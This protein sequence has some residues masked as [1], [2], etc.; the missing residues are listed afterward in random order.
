VR[1]WGR[2]ARK[3]LRGLTARVSYL[4]SRSSGE[5][6]NCQW[7]DAPS[8]DERAV[9]AVSLL[10]R[11]LLKTNPTG[12]L[13]IADFGAGN[14]RLRRTLDAE[15]DLVHKY[16]AYDVRPQKAT[17]TQID[18]ANE[19]PTQHFDV[20]F[21]LGLLEYVADIPDFLT[22]LARVC[23]AAVLSYVV[24]DGS[25]RLSTDERSARGW[26]SHLT[27]NQLESEFEHAGFASVDFVSVNRGR[28]GIWFTETLKSSS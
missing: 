26:R 27:H 9:Q 25:E 2:H 15:L 14:E 12:P 21:C 6:F 20:V 24:L 10:S 7:Q 3:T 18:L 5:K 16:H 11:H 4:W 8:W 1:H 13:S 22:R 23:D 28:T 19:F 17:T